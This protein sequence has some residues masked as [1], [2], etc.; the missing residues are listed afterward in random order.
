[1]RSCSSFSISF[2]V[3]SR[4]TVSYTHLDVYKRQR[5]RDTA[6]ILYFIYIAMTVLQTIL[7]VCGGMPLFDSL[8][9]TFGTAG[10]GGF[11][12]KSDGVAA[13]SY[14][15]LDVYKRQGKYSRCEFRHVTVGGEIY[16]ALEFTLATTGCAVLISTDEETRRAGIDPASLPDETARAKS[17]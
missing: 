17:K 6:K 16:T 14:T 8:L 12:I 15:H 3:G 2:S 10:T 7:L 5:I 1:M 13:V 9:H 11:G 4:G